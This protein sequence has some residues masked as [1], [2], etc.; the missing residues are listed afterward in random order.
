MAITWSP[1]RHIR[2]RS[3]TDSTNPDISIPGISTASP[4]GSGYPP[5]RWTMSARLSAVATIRTST[6]SGPG[7]GTGT[8]SILSTSGPPWV[9]NTTALIGAVSYT[10]RMADGSFDHTVGSLE[11]LRAI[12]RPPHH[13]VVE[14][15]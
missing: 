9:R 15:E 7:T 2:T 5:V 10:R 13:A 12:Y 4:R 11:A 3:P 6:S 8:S 1:G 14:K